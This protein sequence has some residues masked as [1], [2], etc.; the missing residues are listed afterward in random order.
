VAGLGRNDRCPCGSGRKVK[1]CCGVSPGPSQAELDGAYLAASARAAALTL[2]DLSYDDLDELW[3][4][5]FDLPAQH[6]SL[7]VELPELLTPEV[8][9]L[10]RAVAAD[11][12]DE[13]WA[14]FPLVLARYDTSSTRARIV[15]AVVALRQGGEIEGDL[16]AVAVVDLAEPG[17]A[18]IQA[19]LL[20]SVAVAT[21]TERTPAG[22]ILASAASQARG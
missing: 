2:G 22:L 21:G 3:G 20:H 9:R 17:G 10:L 7:M 1:R 4:R 6:L 15:R 16:A 18:L 13:A 5:L 19:S 8:D 11:D 12:P 14:A